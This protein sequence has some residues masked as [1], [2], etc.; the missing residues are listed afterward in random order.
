MP[1]HGRGLLK[2]GGDHPRPGRP[3]NELRGTLREILERGLPVLEGYVEG[4]VPVKMVGKCEKCG[5]EH[6]DYELL[7]TD[8]MLLQTV[9][10]TDRLKALEIAAR[11]GGVDKLSLMLDEQPER[12]LTPERIAALWDQLE[13]IK[14]VKEFEKMLVDSAEKQAAAQGG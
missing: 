12:E 9:K 4:R 13:Q 11:Y 8:L 3:P 7:P 2:Q 10:A 14:T 1:R 6:E 5:H